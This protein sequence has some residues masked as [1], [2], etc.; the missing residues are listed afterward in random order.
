MPLGGRAGVLP[1]VVCALLCVD[2]A[3]TMQTMLIA[4]NRLAAMVRWGGWG[5]FCGSCR[6][7]G[8]AIGLALSNGFGV[9]KIGLTRRFPEDNEKWPVASVF[10]QQRFFRDSRR[11]PDAAILR[12]VMIF[13]T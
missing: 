12:G 13:E 9:Q 10:N 1:I 8:T 5:Q 4:S 6:L 3:I 7:C 11:E 2:V